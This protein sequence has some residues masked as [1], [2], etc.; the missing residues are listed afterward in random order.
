MEWH[1]KLAATLVELGFHTSRSNA[2]LFLRTSPSP[3]YILI[4]VDN[5]ILLGELERLLSTGSAFLSGLWLLSRQPFISW[6]SMRSSAF[7]LSSCEAELYAATMAVQE[8]C[9]LTFLL[10]ELGA[11]RRCPTFW[12]DNASTIHLTKDAVY[13]GRSKHIELCYF[14]IRD[15]TQAR[16][17]CLGKIDSA[18][19]LTDIFTKSLP[20]ASHSSLICLVASL[21]HRSCLPHNYPF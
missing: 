21:P 20:H 12:C 19:N 14:F 7:T 11:P 18:A 10:D 4:N 15:L 5:M 6:Q 8:G 2:S 9:W 16:H 1:A 13:H 17:R 3:F